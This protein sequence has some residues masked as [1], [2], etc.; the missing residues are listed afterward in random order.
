MSLTKYADRQSGTYSG[1]NKRKLSVAIALV[2]EPSVVLLDEPST[3][4]DPEARRC[5]WDVISDSTRGRTIVLTS[6]SMEECE[7]RSISHWSP[8]DRVGVVNAVS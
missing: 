8:Y 2:G 1:G 5:L 3:G 4:M 6:H 7:A